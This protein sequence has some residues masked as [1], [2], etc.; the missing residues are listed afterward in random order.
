MIGIVVVGHGE[1]GHGIASS[2]ELIAGKQEQFEVLSFLEGEEND[3]IVN[4]KT[5]VEKVD[6]GDGVIIFT[7]LK[8]GSPF[9]E[10]VIVAHEYEKCE[11]LTGTNV[12]MLLEALLAREFN[13]SVSDFASA[14]E[15]T[16]KEQVYLFSLE[17]IDEP[18]THQ[19][20]E[21]I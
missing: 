19:D 16:G 8:G 7:D 21:G 6:Q 12:A 14:L 5:A 2:V 20:N 17:T 15:T 4:L 1:F 11:V 13:D 10:S 18:E 9:R 3:L